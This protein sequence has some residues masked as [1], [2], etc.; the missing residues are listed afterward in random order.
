MFAVINTI[1]LGESSVEEIFHYSVSLLIYLSTGVIDWFCSCFVTI[2]LHNEPSKLIS[3]FVLVV[4][5]E[6]LWQLI[7]SYML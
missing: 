1:S 2:L 7:G 6:G 4:V 3:V 5:F